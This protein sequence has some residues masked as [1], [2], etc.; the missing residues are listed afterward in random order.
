MTSWAPLGRPPPSDRG[1]APL[2]PPPPGDRGWARLGPPPPCD[3]GWARLGR[4]LTRVTQ[5]LSLLGL[6]LPYVSTW[7]IPGRGA[8]VATCQ[9]LLWPRVQ[10]QPGTWTHREVLNC[11]WPSPGQSQG[12]EDSSQAVAGG[13]W[14]RGPGEWGRA[15]WQDLCLSPEGE[16]KALPNLPVR[17]GPQAPQPVT[18]H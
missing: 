15:V 5:S 12:H 7:S 1:W 9:P 6:Q 16:G 2:G 17:P 4:P 8:E 10:P 3:R 14:G 18:Q 13:L 11:P